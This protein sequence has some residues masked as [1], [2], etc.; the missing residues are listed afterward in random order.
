LQK[1]NYWASIGEGMIFELGQKNIFF[2]FMNPS[3][4]LILVFPKLYPLT[5]PG[6]ALCIDLGQKF[7]NLF[8]LV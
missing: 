8:S 5:A 2:S 1:K 7:Q 4:E 6:M 3:Y